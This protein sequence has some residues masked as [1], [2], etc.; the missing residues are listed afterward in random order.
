MERATKKTTKR[1]VARHFSFRFTVIVIIYIFF[2]VIWWLLLLK[3]G[4]G[5]DLSSP[6]F[7]GYKVDFYLDEVAELKFIML[8]QI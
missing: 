1:T 4:V 8:F 3:L 2:L 6:A 7:V 5:R